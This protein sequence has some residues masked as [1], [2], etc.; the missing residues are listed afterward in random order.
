MFR[1]GR[2]GTRGNRVKRRPKSDAQHRTGGIT[3]N[4]AGVAAKTGQTPFQS[5]PGQYQVGIL[6]PGTVGDSARN[7]A[8][9]NTNLKVRLWLALNIPNRRVGVLFQ[10]NLKLAFHRR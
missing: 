5:A 6:L 2:F 10:R 8:S 1:S 3:N 7:F 9:F 4:G